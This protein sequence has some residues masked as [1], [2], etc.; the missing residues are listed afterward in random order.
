LTTSANFVGSAIT[1]D[2]KY[3]SNNAVNDFVN[4]KVK[5]GAPDAT[6][7]VKGIVQLAG[8][9][10]GTAELP[11]VAS[12]AIDS[13][14][15][16]SN[17]V[18][19]AKILDANV[20]TSKIADLGVTAAKIANNTITS[21]QIAA[22]TITAGQISNNTITSAQIAGKTITEA[23]IADNTITNVKIGETIS[24]AKGG[25]GVSTFANGYI[26]KG[27]GNMLTSVPAIP[28]SDVTNA[29]TILN[30]ATDFTVKDNIKYPTTQAVN[31]FV[32]TKIA[33][34][35]PDASITNKGIVQ[36]AGDL[37][38][39]ALF[40]TVPGL[41]LKAPLI[42]PGLTGTPTA[43]TAAKGDSSIQLANTEFVTTAITAAATP[44]ATNL[45]KGKIKLAGDLAGSANAPPVT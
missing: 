5:E 23:Q 33:E 25:S 31:D 41:L 43:P 4:R 8:D 37:S 38:G 29:E 14:K 44:D 27:N 45:V 9:L 20:T 11:R 15:I 39:T 19:T 10:T 36:L 21:G 16:A 7:L 42:S 2:D 3:P 18:T 17:A 32:I 12:S 6:T 34:G 22:N 40:P 24:I 30:K 26:T 13:N 28:V 35:A 1:A